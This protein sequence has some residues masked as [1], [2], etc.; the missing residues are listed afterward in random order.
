MWVLA[1]L[2]LGCGEQGSYELRWSVESVKPSAKACMISSVR[3]CTQFGLDAMSVTVDRG[4]EAVE[5]SVFPCFVVGDGP[6]GAGPGLDPGEVTLWVSGLSA[7]GQPFLGPV[8]AAV[9]IPNEGLTPVR[10]TLPRPSQCNDGIDNDGDGMVDGVDPQCGG[11]ATLEGI[12][13]CADGKDNDGDKLVDLLD[14]DCTDAKLDS[15]RSDGCS[16]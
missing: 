2:A 15:E 1:P 10:V 12:A 8:K 13:R 9:T 11:S 6:V 3:H 16:W 4:G 7:A 14:P 5:E